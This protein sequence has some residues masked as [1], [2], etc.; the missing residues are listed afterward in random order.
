MKK[1][2]S[3]SG[4]TSAFC[5]F[6][7]PESHRKPPQPHGASLQRG[8]P[9]QGTLPSFP[10]TAPFSRAAVPKALPQGEEAEQPAFADYCWPC[11]RARLAPPAPQPPSCF[12]PVLRTSKEGWGVATQKLTSCVAFVW[13]G[14][15]HAVSSFLNLNIANQCLQAPTYVL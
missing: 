2:E 11:C 14:C 3:I 8:L 9:A 5:L 12:W 7:K 1:L 6:S 13:L 4:G 10:A 15:S